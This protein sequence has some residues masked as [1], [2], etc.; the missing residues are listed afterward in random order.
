MHILPL[1]GTFRQHFR[2][3]NL[4]VPAFFNGRLFRQ[5]HKLQRRENT[6]YVS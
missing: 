3:L 2:A 6:N 5:A 4:G 1:T